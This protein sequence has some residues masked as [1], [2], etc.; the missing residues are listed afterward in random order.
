MQF[1]MSTASSKKNC[2]Q[3]S[4]EY[5]AY[6]SVESSEDSKYQYVSYVSYAGMDY[7]IGQVGN[8]L[9]PRTFG[10]PAL[11]RPC[12]PKNPLLWTAEN[13]LIIGRKYF[14][15]IRFAMSTYHV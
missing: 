10:A 1:L 3:Y 13:R 5:L 11:C 6:G 8:G 12:P 7:G 14:P 15:R 2:R 9:G 4:I